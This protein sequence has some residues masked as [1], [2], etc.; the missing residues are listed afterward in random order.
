MMEYI[1]DPTI[2]RKVKA[3]LAGAEKPRQAEQTRPPQGGFFHALAADCAMV[4][5]RRW[6]AH[7]EHR[8]PGCTFLRQAH[9]AYTVQKHILPMRTISTTGRTGGMRKAP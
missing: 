7:R 3:M 8:F 2:L 4:R 5:E 9:S 6:P 1:S